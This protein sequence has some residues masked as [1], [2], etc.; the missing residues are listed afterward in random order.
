MTDWTQ[1]DTSLLHS[2]VLQCPGQRNLGCWGILAYNFFFFMW[3][4]QCVCQRTEKSSLWL[5]ASRSAELQMHHHPSTLVDTYS[6]LIWELYLIWLCS[7]VWPLNLYPRHFI[8]LRQAANQK[9][10]LTMEAA[11]GPTCHPSQSGRGPICVSAEGLTETGAAACMAHW[12]CNYPGPQRERGEPW[13][14]RTFMSHT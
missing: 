9:Q 7:S 13:E 3:K 4:I 6:T 5:F 8:C 1:A 2:E 14:A 12:Q 11:G 10:A